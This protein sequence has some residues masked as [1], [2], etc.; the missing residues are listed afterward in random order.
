MAHDPCPKSPMKTFSQAQVAPW[1]GKQVQR[2]DLEA[3]PILLPEIFARLR[4][5]GASC[6]AVFG[7]AARDTDLSALWGAERPI[8]DYDMRCWLPPTVFFLDDWEAGFGL[9][10]M[11][12]FEGSS[13]AMEPSAGTGRLRH[14]I[15]W[16]GLELDIS[17]RKRPAASSSSE[18]CARERA[19]DG[20]ASLSSVAIDESL[21]GW[22]ESLYAIDRKERAISYYPG[23]YPQ[24]LEAYRERMR[25]KFPRLAERYP[26]Q[27]LGS[28]TTSIKVDAT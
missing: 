22:C 4:K 19:L 13:L 5:A 28:G 24:R 23:Q 17:A 11:G 20:D 21:S 14:V 3:I 1:M 15:R 26:W 27:P 9:A 8:K 12:A 16:R 18:D 6:S 25:A 10:L 7:G 2:I